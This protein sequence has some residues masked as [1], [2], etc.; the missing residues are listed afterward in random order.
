MQV[1][2]P[3]EETDAEALRHQLEEASAMVRHQAAEIAQHEATIAAQRSEIGQLQEQLNVILSRRYAQSAE[4]VSDAQLGLFNE[5][6][7]TLEEDADGEDSADAVDADAGTEV[8]A[9]VRRRGKRKPLPEHLERVDIEHELPEAERTCPQHDVA[10]KRFAEEVS[11]QLD[12]IPA[13]IRVLRHVRGKYRCPCCEGHLVTAP[14][15]AQPIPKSMASPGLLAYIAVAKFCDALPLYRQTQQFGRIGVEF[16]RTTL[17]AWMVKMGQLVQS[18]INLL[19]ERLLEKGYV[20]MDETRVQV[21]AEAGK[22]AESQ[23]YLWA[24]RTVGMNPIVLFDYDP[25]RSSAVPVRLLEGFSGTLHTDGYRG[26]D[27]VVE[28][29]NL[30]RLYCFAHARRKFVEVIKGAGINPKKI[31]NKPPPQVRAALKPINF[32]KTLYAIERR[33]QELPPDER[34]RQRQRDSVPVLN[35]LRAWLDDRLKR[36]L[37]S[38]KMGQAITYLDNQWSGLT[39]YVE[40]GRYR[41]DTNLIENAIRPFCVGRKNWLFSQS[42][43][44]AKASANLYSLIETAKANGVEPYAYLRHVFTELPKAN[45]V[46]DIEALL[47]DHVDVAAITPA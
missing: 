34:Y 12:I 9:H 23:S 1:T 2:D 29:Q 36:V 31:P 16:S 47:P 6:E 39:R 19:R 46:E 22:P 18:L 3:I 37:P 5:A 10:L 15:P 35:K 41:I 7:E 25:T 14:M 8:A 28:S 32:I 45:T 13:K 38:G 27:G 20:L 21:L 4:K 17:A 11:E 24:Q 43:A 42:V 40:D 33:I 44:G 26:Y 30:T